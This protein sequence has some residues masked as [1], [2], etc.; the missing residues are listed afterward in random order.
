MRPTSLR[1]ALAVC[2]LALTLAA[3]AIAA[4]V[5]HPD[6]AGTRSLSLQGRVLAYSLRG[7][8]L[9]IALESRTG[10]NVLAWHAGDGRAVPT[11]RAC[12]SVAAAPRPKLTRAR[13]VTGTVD[14]PD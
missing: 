8:T 6:P 3:P 14:T 13:I 12:A 9:D 7:S 1:L 11:A 4:Y 10:C 5:C 2:A